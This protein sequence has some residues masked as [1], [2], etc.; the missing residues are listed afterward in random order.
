MTTPQIKFVYS[1]GEQPLLE[2]LKSIWC[3]TDGADKYSDVKF[4]PLIKKLQLSLMALVHHPLQS[5]ILLIIFVCILFSNI[6]LHP[7]NS[8]NHVIYRNFLNIP[9]IKIYYEHSQ[10]DSIN[11]YRTYSYPNQIKGE[12][13]KN[14]QANIYLYYMPDN[15]YEPYISKCAIDKQGFFIKCAE[16]INGF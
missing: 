7:D 11:P 15:I 9:K 3:N 5:F 12:P 13:F 10:N 14:N 1:F 8:Q 16:S 6:G 4:I 2:D